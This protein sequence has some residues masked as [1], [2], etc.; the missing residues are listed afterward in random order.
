[1]GIIASASVSAVASKS[2][3]VG[4]RQ[5]VKAV[6][7]HVFI[8][9]PFANCGLYPIPITQ[10]TEIPGDQI[11]VNK[12]A[13]LMRSPSRWEVLVFRLLGTFYIKRLL[14]LPGEEIMLCNGDLYVNGQLMRKS[15]AEARAMRVLVFDQNNAPQQGWKDRWE[16]DQPSAQATGTTLALRS[17]T[18]TYRHYLLDTGK[19]EPI[20][21]EYAY[22]GGLHA[23]SECVHD[24]LI[25]TEIEASAARG[26]LALRLCDGHDWV[27]VLLPVGERRAIEAFAWPTDTKEQMRQLAATAKPGSL[28]SK[29]RYR[30][31][32][33]F[34]DRRLSLAVDGQV[35]LSADLP[36]AKKRGE[37][38]R[39]FQAEAD[40]VAVNLHRFRLY[41]DVHYTQQGSNAVRGKSVRL[42]VN[43]YF[44]LG[45]NSPNSEDSRFWPD[46]GRID[47]AC[48]IGPIWGAKGR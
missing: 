25:E 43:Q 40:G 39:P 37:V 47:A 18:L 13:L 38:V 7:R 48:L 16:L 20:R 32:M 45:D 10:T 44:M 24:F 2:S 15:F 1:M 11:F 41:R 29:R 3:S 34:V 33:A 36:A 17:G 21:D 8:A 14:G 46:D 27:E 31:E 12:T 42:G 35:W 30:I 4:I 5:I 19:C 22:N 23:D 26:S 9:R 28:Q 6:V